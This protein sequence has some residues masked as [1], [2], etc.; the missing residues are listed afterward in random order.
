M[1]IENHKG[2]SNSRSADKG[3]RGREDMKM[4]TTAL[5]ITNKVETG[6]SKKIYKITLVYEET[7]TDGTNIFAKYSLPIKLAETYSAGTA[8][9]IAKAMADLY[10]NAEHADHIEIN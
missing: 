2:H 5:R 9:V 8:Y 1:Y 3:Q 6:R 4:T 10:S 7:Y